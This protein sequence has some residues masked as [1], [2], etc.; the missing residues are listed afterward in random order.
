MV[1]FKDTNS[2]NTFT[3]I[4]KPGVY[5][6]KLI[7][8][9][10][11]LQDDKFAID[12][13]GNPTEPKELISFVWDVAT[14]DGTQCHVDTKPCMVSFSEKSKLPEMWGNVVELSDMSDYY[15]FFYDK[16]DKLKSVNAQVMVK[17]Q[18]KDGKVYN[19]VSEVVSLEDS[20]DI[21]PTPIT[22]YDLRVYGKPCQD[23]DL[24]AEYDNLPGNS[25]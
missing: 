18:E 7:A 17:V 9:R 1:K 14:N 5:K 11:S 15:D 16:N 6:A 3:F 10:Q 25:R 22:E 24:T 13:E 20:V 4:S 8:L 12:K 19:K 23:Y 21:K 2:S